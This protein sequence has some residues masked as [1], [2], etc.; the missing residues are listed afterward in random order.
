MHSGFDPAE[1]IPPPRGDMRRRAAARAAT[2]HDV[3]RLAGVSQP[4]V[5]RA[6]RGRSGVSDETRRRVEEAARTLNYVASDIGRSLATRSR[7]QIGMVAR[8]LTN[9]FYP[10]L[11]APA[12][13]EL[14]RA[15]YRM[16]L[17]TEREDDPTAVERLLDQSIDGAILTTSTA[18]TLLPQE[19]ARRST[20][21]V[22]LNREVRSIEADA[23]LVDNALGGA[24]VADA[25]A[26]LGHRRIAA[27]FGPRDTSTGYER[28]MAFR[29]RLSEHGIPLPA[30]NVRHGPYAYDTGREL[31]ADLL[32]GDADFSA[33]F[34]GNDVIAMGAL[35]CTRARGVNV[36]GDLT[37]IGFDDIPMASW[38]VFGLTTVRTDLEAMARSACRLLLARIADPDRG[39]ERTLFTPQF[40][41]RGTHAP[42]PTS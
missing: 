9:P 19:L 26:E 40:T 13:D 4:T 1:D 15:G 5:S 11:V 32:D 42:P 18:H 6:L 33:V 39:A 16:V 14:D 38:E 30:R 28:E 2:S 27:I 23:C 17:F 35:S 29:E 31:L 22:F 25:L 20:P 41:P 21:F 36:P 7:M 8:E 10:H 3:A 37:V 12:Q 24:L 34:C